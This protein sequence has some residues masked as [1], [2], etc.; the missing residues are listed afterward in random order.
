MVVPVLNEGETSRAR[1]LAHHLCYHRPNIYWK[2]AKGVIKTWSRYERWNR[3]E[4][5][6][7]TPTAE[8][9]NSNITCVVEYDANIVAE[10]TVTLTVQ[11]KFELK[12]KPSWC[13]IVLLTFRGVYQCHFITLFIS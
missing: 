3:Q 1:C 2:G 5:V 10:K 11:C 13:K 12:D 7:L 4:H 8:D 9:H 6:H